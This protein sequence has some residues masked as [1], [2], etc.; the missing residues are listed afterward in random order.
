MKTESVL[1]DW[2]GLTE[3][4]VA[5]FREKGSFGPVQRPKL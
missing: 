4:Q 5:E 2:L 1:R 3:Q